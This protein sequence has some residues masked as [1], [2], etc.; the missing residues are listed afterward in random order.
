MRKGLTD[1]HWRWITVPRDKADAVDAY[2][3]SLL[4]SRVLRAYEVE[5]WLGTPF[6]RYSLHPGSRMRRTP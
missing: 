1:L 3:H 2:L 6:M 4:R 5:S